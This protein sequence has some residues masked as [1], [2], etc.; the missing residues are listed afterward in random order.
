M[1]SLFIAV[2]GLLC[3]APTVT[4]ERYFPLANVFQQQPD[5]MMTSSTTGFEST[6]GAATVTNITKYNHLRGGGVKK[7]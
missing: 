5:D 2:L 6:T 1:K 4:A 3:I 7:V